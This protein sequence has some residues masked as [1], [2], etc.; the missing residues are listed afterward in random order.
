MIRLTKLKNMI[1]R[2]EDKISSKKILSLLKIVK[3]ILYLFLVANFFACLMFLVSSSDLSPGT[4][5]NLLISSPNGFITS[6]EELY[7]DS[8][9]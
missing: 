8:L 1:M 3:L 9:Y 6:P 7:I 2:I 4:F 5:A